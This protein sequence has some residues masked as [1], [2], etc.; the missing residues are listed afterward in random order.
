VRRL[1]SAA[2]VEPSSVPPSSI[3][4]VRALDDPARGE[5]LRDTDA[6]VAP[7][8]WRHAMQRRLDDLVR[9]AARPV[10]E[11]VPGSAASVF[12]RDQS[13]LIACLSRDFLRGALS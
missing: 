11:I 8:R 12:F 6:A 9:S 7:T 5:L 13:E 1:L 10:S 3:L 4:I 2:D